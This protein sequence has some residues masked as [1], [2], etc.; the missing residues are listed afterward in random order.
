MNS[1]RV[2]TIE[3]RVRQFA[4]PTVEEKEACSHLAQ[5]QVV[6]PNSEGCEQC[7]EL[8]DTWVNLRLCMTCGQ[9]GCCDDSKNQHASKHHHV[10]GHPIIMSYQP[11]EEWM[12][13]YVDEVLFK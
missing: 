4:E 12:W 6:K 5:L 3:R 1:D 10:S 11:N 2:V 8:G 7:I 13:C 9:I